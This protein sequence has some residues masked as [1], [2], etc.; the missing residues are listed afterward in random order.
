MGV[1]AIVVGDGAMLFQT[2]ILQADG[3]YDFHFP[4]PPAWAAL[5]D[6]VATAPNTQVR[7]YVSSTEV[8][9]NLTLAVASPTMTST[10]MYGSGVA[11]SGAAGAAPVAG[12]INYMLEW[13]DGQV[14]LRVYNKLAGAV[15]AK[16]RLLVPW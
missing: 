3:V 5:L 12:K 8:G 9:A 16:A 13:V 4:A 15:M 11:V 6:A 14:R 10:G 2:P 1:Q 7:C